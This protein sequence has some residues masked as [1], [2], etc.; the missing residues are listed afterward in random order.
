MYVAHDTAR[1]SAGGAR[2]PADPITLATTA[3]ADRTAEEAAG[4]SS[5]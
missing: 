4:F 1:V 2:H 3:K 5:G